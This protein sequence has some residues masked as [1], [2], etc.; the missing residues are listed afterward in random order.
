M[1]KRR[2]LSILELAISVAIIGLVIIF[3]IG[4]YSTFF[5]SGTK[6]NEQ[7]IG[8]SIAKSYI[9]RFYF[10]ANNYQQY[11]RDFNSIIR[12]QG[13]NQGREVSNIVQFGLYKA[14]FIGNRNYRLQL[15]GDRIYE[16]P[17][18]NI[19]LISA[20]VYWKE[21]VQRRTFIRG[22]GKNFIVLR[23]I[24]SVDK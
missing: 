11:S 12:N 24:V 18:N 8:F 21:G 9:D 23:K 2:G 20:G 15:V 16:G 17:T 4:M 22:Y 14:Q 7:T 3:I 6:I 5:T 13:Q 10:Y 1:G 19:Y